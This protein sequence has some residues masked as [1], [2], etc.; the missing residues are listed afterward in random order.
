MTHLELLHFDVFLPGLRA[1]TLLLFLLATPVQC[2]AGRRFH[3]AA[4][5]ALQRRSPNMDVLIS[6]ATC[7]AYGYSSLMML[8][9]VVFA[10]LG[11]AQE[12]PP[13]HFFET[14]CS[15]IT[16][17]LFGR[18]LEATAKKRTTDSLDQLVRSSPEMARVEGELVHREL[19]AVGAG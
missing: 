14:P 3:A 15:L 11:E 10:V 12:E 8:L 1:E 2:L 5:A 7:L 19:V 9:S 17:V 6:C 4:R 16:V 18:V 13:P